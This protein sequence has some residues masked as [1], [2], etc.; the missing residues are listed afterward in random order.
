MEQ[1]IA[2]RNR[3]DDEDLVSESVGVRMTRK[4]GSGTVPEVRFST[5]IKGR[6]GFPAYAGASMTLENVFDY[7]TVSSKVRYVIETYECG[8]GLVE[9]KDTG[10]IEKASSQNSFTIDI[11]GY[12]GEFY[13]KSKLQVMEYTLDGAVWSGQT[14]TATSP[15]ITL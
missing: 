4:S 6:N 11:D 7:D 12:S 2:P 5:S 9:Q 1:T 15:C 8:G 13:V 14:Q 3:T 10:V